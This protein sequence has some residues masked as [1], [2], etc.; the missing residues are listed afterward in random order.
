[1]LEVLLEGRDEPFPYP[2]GK[3]LEK[4]NSPQPTLPKRRF[5]LRRWKKN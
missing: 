5:L 1:V 3:E 2:M 4:H